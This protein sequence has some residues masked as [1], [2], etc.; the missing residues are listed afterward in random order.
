[1]EGPMERTREQILESRARQL[2]APKRQAKTQEQV[3]DLLAFISMG[4][5]YALPL[6][7]VE[8]VGHIEDVVPVPQTPTHIA[9]IIRR[10]GRAIALVD[11][12]RFFQPN[13]QGISD[14]DYA[15]VVSAKGKQFAL[16]V[17]NIEGVVNIDKKTLLP[18]PENLDP[19]QAPYISAATIDGLC[20]ID[21]DRLI[22]AEGFTASRPT[23][24]RQK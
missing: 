15:I 6:A 19:G 2:A 5:R 9:G 20:V 16:E 23:L 4:T 11:I 13:I 24:S 1:M 8:S 12:R 3:V 17:E 22:D 21:L 10:S 7:R 18:P 14:S